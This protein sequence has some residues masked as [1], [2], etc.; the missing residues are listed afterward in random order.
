MSH[1][2]KPER[3]ATPLTTCSPSSV[4]P[5]LPESK[6]LSQAF[7]KISAGQKLFS[8]KTHSDTSNF[9]NK[10]VVGN[11]HASILPRGLR[12]LPEAMSLFDISK[13]SFFQLPGISGRNLKDSTVEKIDFQNL[14]GPLTIGSFHIE[15]T[16]SIRQDVQEDQ[17]EC[18]S[19]DIGSINNFNFK[20]CSV[21]IPS[22]ENR[23]VSSRQSLSLLQDKL[24]RFKRISK[25]SQESVGQK[26]TEIKKR[27]IT[28][29]CNC[30]N[31]RC[32]KLYCECFK[33]NGYC[34]SKCSCSNCRNT[35]T[36]ESEREVQLSKLK[37]PLSID[38][39]QKSEKKSGQPQVPIEES[40]PLAC[41]CRQSGCLKNY[42]ECFASGRGCAENCYCRNCKNGESTALS[43]T[44][45]NRV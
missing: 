3:D 21:L 18:L 33:V 23:T 44:K 6:V 2:A 34:S 25:G 17:F 11:F 29:A 15:T 13:G 24:P 4:G 28:K 39:C 5:Q 19:I 10:N 37:L 7:A 22:L 30:R 35:P 36:Y 41:R 9:P 1:A 8:S 45:V 40:K 43:P 32:L 26:V 12:N 42:C 31:S 38:S 20:G 27:K 14:V 16:E